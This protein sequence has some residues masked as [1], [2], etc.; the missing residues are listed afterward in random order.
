V[1]LLPRD[2]ESVV[3]SRPLVSG[4]AKASSSRPLGRPSETAIAACLL[5]L[6]FSS[7]ACTYRG[8]VPVELPAISYEEASPAI[9]GPVTLC[10]SKR[11]RSRTWR[12]DPRFY[13]V[14]L[15]RKAA[16]A[17]E[18][19]VKASIREVR[20]DFAKGC[21][22]RATGPWLDAKIDVADR[23]F[24]EHGDT[25]TRVVL[26]LTLLDA[27]GEVVWSHAGEGE[28]VDSLAALEL[29]HRE[30]ALDFGLALE[31]ALRKTYDALSTSETVRRELGE[32][33][34]EKPQSPSE[35]VPQSSPPPDTASLERSTAIG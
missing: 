31:A 28:V 1:S 35:P 7:G 23:A 11:L 34:E 5:T 14:H 21:G 17:V 16:L 32:L 8:N 18:Q 27:S 30:A 3:G 2:G 15:G 33:G 12:E 22:K 4:G 25:V 20:I 13:T 19:L 10:L 24:D 26:T 6:L 29:D 9:E